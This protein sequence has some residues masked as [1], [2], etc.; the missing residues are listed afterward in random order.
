MLGWAALAGLAFAWL[1]VRLGLPPGGAL[2]DADRVPVCDGL[3]RRLPAAA[4][5]VLG[6]ERL[7]I[8]EVRF[9]EWLFRVMQVGWA[10]MHLSL[11]SGRR[12]SLSYRLC[13]DL[14][15]GPFGQDQPWGAILPTGLGLML[16]LTYSPPQTGAFLVVFLLAS[17]LL[18]VRTNLIARQ[19]GPAT[20]GDGLSQRHRAR[21]FDL[22]ARLFRP[23]YPGRLDRAPD[24]AGSAVVCGVADAVY[25]PWNEF[26]DQFGRMFSTLRSVSLARPP[27]SGQSLV[28]GGPVRLGTAPV[29]DIASETGRYWA[30]TFDRYTGVGWVSGSQEISH[31]AP[32]DPRL[33][34]TPFG[35]AS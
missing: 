30:T 11:C 26:T 24:S 1:V 2:A 18:L 25:R 9:G 28:L 33:L 35:V 31:F 20:R 15:W 23:D 32:N 13:R 21:L 16:N 4:G 19:R 10:R 27:D 29:M 6:N 3:A 34:D 5:C 7:V 8:T 14:V 12:P 22:R 17:L